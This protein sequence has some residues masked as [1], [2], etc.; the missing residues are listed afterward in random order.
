M[1]MPSDWTSYL[2]SGYRWNVQP[3]GT[4]TFSFYETGSTLYGSTPTGISE[5]PDAVK[6]NIRGIMSAMERFIAIDFVEVAD[7]SSTYGQLRFMNDTGTSYAYAYY[8]ST[9]GSGAAGDVH[10][11]PSY[12]NTGSNGWASAPGNHGYQALWHEIGHA[13]GL[14]H[15]FEGSVQA[16]AGLD[17]FNF[18]T[19]TYNFTGG[20]PTSWMPGDI[21]VLQQIYGANT[22]WAAG[23]TVYTFSQTDAFSDGTASYGTASLNALAVIWDGGGNDTL[24]LSAVSTS[25]LRIDLTPGTGIVT[26]ASA[27]NTTSYSDNWGTKEAGTFYLTATGSFIAYNV[28]IENAIGSAAADIIIGNAADNVLDG[29]AGADQMSGGAGDDTYVV[30]NAGDVVTEAASAGYD[31]V[32]AGISYVLPANVE[33]LYLPGTAAINGTGNALNNTLYGNGAANVLDGGAGADALVGG[34]GNDIYY[35]DNVGDVVQEYSAGGS[36][37]I[38]TSVSYTLPAEVEYLWLLGSTGTSI[39]K[40]LTLVDVARHAKVSPMAVSHV[41]F[42][43][44]EG[45]IRVGA[46]RRRES[47]LRRRVGLRPQSSRAAVGGEKSGIVGVIANDWQHPTELRV[48]AYIQYWADH[49]GFRVLALQANKKLD[50]IKEYVADFSSRGIDGLLF[51]AYG[52]DDLWP[53]LQEVLRPIQH[54]IALLGQPLLE[55]GC[56]IDCDYA[57][58]AMMA[59]KHLR[60]QGRKKIVQVLEDLDSQPNRERWR[61]FLDAHR[62][63][64]VE[65]GEEQ[66]CIATKDWEPDHEGFVDLVDD[67]VRRR[68]A[69]AIMADSDLGAVSLLR[70]IRRK[71][72]RVPDDVAVMGWGNE[73]PGR[74]FD[75][76]IS[77]VNVMI[78]ETVGAAMEILSAMVNEKAEVVAES[79]LIEP[80]LMIRETA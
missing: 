12:N 28:T 45:V 5:V 79:R 11:N 9:W 43:T 80:E 32:Y 3:G 22:G 54:V 47:P 46:K 25:G 4:L 13:L 56:S 16:P 7:S 31:Q 6:D 33:K 64:G 24:D 60:G 41:L 71:G 39:K 68:G 30:D 65:A 35:I 66:L 8:P 20:E 74:W 2:D 72:I 15:P 70:V 42:G 36:D 26:N 34:N 17:N 78:R 1:G 76:P 37:R 67:L 57:Q 48:L 44:G 49:Y 77:S 61:G 10:L 62:E 73:N 69:D 21:Y 58:G 23:D 63:L 75:P 55:S 38:F 19:M 14:K 29:G 50:P 51:L 27:Y 40:R 18:T 52:N 53:Q 59:V